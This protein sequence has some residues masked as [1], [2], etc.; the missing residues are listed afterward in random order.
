[1]KKKFILSA[2]ILLILVIFGFLFHY[3]SYL[4]SQYH[5]LKRVTNGNI[6]DFKFANT[7]SKQVYFFSDSLKIVGDLYKAE[8]KKAPFLLIAHGIGKLGRKQPIILSLAKEFHKLNYTVLTID[9]RGFN[10]SEPPH[11]IL[12]AKDIDFGKDIISAVNYAVNNLDID[13]SRIYVLGHSFGA[14]VTLSAQIRDRRIKKI[15]LL[16][17]PRR[18][19]ERIINSHSDES[20][21]LLSRQINNMSV[22]EKADTSIL[23]QATQSRNIENYVKE[24]S[25]NNHIPIFLIDCGNENI[26]DL[27]FLRNIY[28]EMTQ[29]KNYW[30]VPDVNHY[31]NT[32]IIFGKPI[33]SGSILNKFVTRVDSWIK[34]TNKVAN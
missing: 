21:F 1:M 33:Y 23:I 16:G 22:I 10:E 30:T 25:S 14:G 34:Q 2:F 15:I 27:K 7:N 29:P 9:F 24:F 4:E 3:R 13:T 12:S 5:E 31:L 6:F 28:G 19:N 32:G 26:K 20:Y 11:K 18:V 17:P 8:L